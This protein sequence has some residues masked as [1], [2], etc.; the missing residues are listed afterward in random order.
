MWIIRGLYELF[1]PDLRQLDR[2]LAHI[3]SSAWADNTVSTRKVQWRKYLSFCEDLGLVGL[4]AETQTVARFLTYLARTSKFNTVNNYLSA[5][6]VLHKYHGFEANFRDTF[7]IQLVIKGLRRILGDNP[8]KA[9]PLSP[10]QLV[11]CY[12][13]MDKL[14]IK[15]MACWASITLC[16]R[17]LLR[18]SNVLPISKACDNHIM[19]RSDVTF[20]PWGMVLTIR[21]SKTIQFRERQLEIPIFLTPNSPLCAVSNLRE[22]WEMFPASAE[23]PLFLKPSKVGPTPLLYSDVLKALKMMVQNIGLDP[24]NVGLHSLRRSGATFLCR[25]GVPLTDIKCAGDWRSLAVLE[26]L[27]TTMDRKLHIESTCAHALLD[28]AC[29]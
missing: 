13:K 15:L 21:S 10:E 6:V 27:V 26:Y 28:M 14:D 8:C 23:S 19:R 25:L 22:H 4:P 11:M 2:E 12:S 3:I 1:L 5:V 24:T 9:I 20:H 18:K 29:F 16:F 17:S 7:Y